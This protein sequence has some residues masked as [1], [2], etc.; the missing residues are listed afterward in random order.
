MSL[1]VKQFSV[2]GFDKNFSY[3][4][5]D[6]DS[7]A[8]AVVD[9]AGDTGIIFDE[10]KSA[11][12]KIEKILLTHTHFDHTEGIGDFIQTFNDIHIYV[13]KNGVE[14]LAEFP[15]IV[16]V[17]DKDL[18]NISD[19]K[20]EVIFT[21]GHSDDSVCF[22]LPETTNDNNEPALISGDTLFVGGCGRTSEHRVKDLYESLYEIKNLPKNTIIYPGHDYGS[23]KTTVLGNEL[24]T[25]KYYQVKNFNEFRRLRLN[26]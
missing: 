13:H 3:I 16:E 14:N 9:P 17:E 12:L 10:I 25:N 22:Y 11:Q 7:K 18:I 6:K 19:N 2:G 24:K 20:I 15:N 8:A 1:S 23:S 26:I 4:I 21:P 5:C